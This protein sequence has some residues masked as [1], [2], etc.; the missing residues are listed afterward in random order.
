MLCMHLYNV[1][2]RYMY[3]MEQKLDLMSSSIRVSTELRNRL[4]R[5]K[6]NIFLNN[7][8]KLSMEELIEMLLDAYEDKEEKKGKKQ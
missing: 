1:T 8:K 5:V 6:A 7:N 3:M 2:Y 4:D